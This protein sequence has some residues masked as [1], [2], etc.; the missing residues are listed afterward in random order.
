MTQSIGGKTRLHIQVCQAVKISVNH[1]FIVIMLLTGQN[2]K[3]MKA[4]EFWRKGKKNNK[5]LKARQKQWK[6]SAHYHTYIM[7]NLQYLSKLRI[8]H[9]EDKGNTKFL[10]QSPSTMWGL[11]KHQD[12]KAFLLLN[13]ICKAFVEIGFM[14]VTKRMAICSKQS[15]SSKRK[16]KSSFCYTPRKYAKCK[17]GRQKICEDCSGK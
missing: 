3:Y 8:A 2:T 4:H 14:T 9:C 12:W 7:R 1:F 10:R 17:G 6:K 15:N 11:R 16:K 13:S 5:V